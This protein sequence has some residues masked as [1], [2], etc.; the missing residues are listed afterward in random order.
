MRRVKIIS[1]LAGIIVMIAV[2]A[3][4]NSFA[5][6][7][8]GSG[9]V[10]ESGTGTESDPYLIISAA[11]LQYLANEVNAGRFGNA[12]FRQ[13]GNIVFTSTDT[14]TAIGI[15]S[16]PF[17]GT[18]D[19]AGFTISGINI[20]K[21]STDYQ[22]LFGCIGANG[23][24]KNVHLHNSTIIGQKYVG[25][26]AGDNFGRIQNCSSI[27]NQITGTVSVGG[28]AGRININAATVESS[29]SSSQVNGGTQVG[30]TVGSIN[31]GLVGQCWSTGNVSASGDHAGGICGYSFNGTIQDCYN[32]GGINGGTGY[33]GGII[34]G[35]LYGKVKN[36][37]NYA[38]VTG[39]SKTGGIIGEYSC[40]SSGTVSNNYFLQ[41]DTINN[42]LYGIASPQSSNGA[43]ARSST[44]MQ[45]DAF[46]YI[47]NT[48]ATTTNSTI[49]SRN[50]D[51]NTGFPH[52]ADNNNRSICKV[53]FKNNGSTFTE[54]Y[55]SYTGLVSF[56]EKP[57]QAGYIFGGWYAD[58][59]GE[60]AA[61]TA[62]SV[63]AQDLTVYAYWFADPGDS[64][65]FEMLYAEKRSESPQ[66]L[67]FKTR[68]YK[69]TLFINNKIEEY[70]TVIL[71]LNLIPAGQS[72]TL[73]TIPANYHADHLPNSKIVI[74]QAV[75]IFTETDDYLVFTGVLTNIPADC[76]AT[77]I[78]ARAYVKYIDNDNNEKIIYSQPVTSSY[79]TA[80]VGQ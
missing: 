32:S 66:G 76:L 65:A 30:G 7:W 79:N 68:L 35:N 46:A 67:R 44:A 10:I 63:L 36:C 29:Y 60:G 73:E 42:G 50:P 64:P 55:S 14:Y 6:A 37:C 20:S 15:S 61:F 57:T 74:I 21:S 59:N 31:Y 71:P 77:D 53:I 2:L 28:I 38:G 24:V 58:N 23:T 62:D 75:N 19:G 25:G 54:A 51:Y 1:W 4:S 47:L 52:I 69:N 72:L 43:E 70:G 41:S 16:K 39:S 78:T 56:P 12:Y 13:T 22:G 48:G 18:Y 40:G 11:N 49:W 5:C 3:C 26:I 33:N 45:T 27:A 8:S 9:A 34:G 17:N 80:S